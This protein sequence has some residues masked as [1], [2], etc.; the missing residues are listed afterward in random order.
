M[1][2]LD[3]VTRYITMFMWAAGIILG[4]LMVILFY[5]LKIKK[6]GSKKEQV[7]YA[8]FV[9]TDSTE[10]VKFKDVLSDTDG[11]FGGMGMVDLG[12]NCFV[13]G[14]NV[15]GYNFA[16]A[17]YEERE[18]TIVNSISLFNIVEEPIQLRQTV[19]AVSLEHNIR[20]Y[21]EIADNLAME[22]LDL[23]EQ[24]TSVM[25]Q[26]EDYVDDNDR[27]ADFEKQLAKIHRNI[28]TK[29]H[30]LQECNM[31]LTFMERITGGEK[32]DMQKVNQVLFSYEYNPDESLEALDENGIRL[33]AMEELH[34]KGTSFMEAFMR[35]GCSTRRITSNEL[36]HLMNRHTHPASADDVTVEDLLESS[37]STIAITSDSLIKFEI[38]RRGEEAINELDKWREYEQLKVEET[39]SEMDRERKVIYDMAKMQ[40]DQREKVANYG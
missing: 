38:E 8:S 29:Q 12:N 9:R 37:D 35:C 5:F 32:R 34:T 33:R 39:V 13:A 19:K 28:M 31:L 17:S 15:S 6:V 36:V 24:Q 10:Y 16:S 21:Q 18:R 25:T 20:V 1:G 27:F 23:D 4:G 14:L 7:N 26:M 11:R 40:A 3:E 30:S 22:L 2:L